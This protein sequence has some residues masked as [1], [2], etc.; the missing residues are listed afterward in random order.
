MA[1]FIKRY[2][3]PGTAPGTLQPRP[4]A[5]A[6]QVVIRL[7]DYDAQEVR[8]HTIT[9]AEECRPYLDRRSITWIHVQGPVQPQTLQELGLLFEL[10]PL[11]LED[12]LNTGQRPKIEAYQ[13]SFF[14]TMA[15]PRREAG[16]IAFDQVSLF[17]GEGFIV[18]FHPGEGDPFEPLRKRVREHNGRFRAR[19]VDYLL[20]ALMD[21]I[22]DQ[23]FPLLDAYGEELEAIEDAVVQNPGKETVH[24]IHSAKRDLFTLR[25]ML[26]PQRDVVNSILRDE[27][28]LVQEETKVY[29]RD[30]YDHA[31]QI[32]DLI[33]SYRELT[34]SL[35]D[36]YLSTT[37][38][39][40]NEVMRL[41][42]VIATIFIPLTFVAGVYGM[43]FAHA[44]SPWAMPELSWYY[45]YPVVLGLMFVIAVGML[46]FFH[47]KGWLWRP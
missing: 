8:E 2:H 47:R 46:L 4:E 36:T 45:G 37:S 6:G 3:P 22:I 16:R 35:L 9:R 29:F 32:I 18:S 39:R 30:C 31:I 43:N 10:H 40:L 26:W 21:L 15:L 14:V 42:T 25:R 23:A 12:V 13:D 20:Y 27:I 44:E 41:L 28:E 38:H 7:M 5:E 19:D 1:H 11:A 34:T 17:C 33:E 24:A